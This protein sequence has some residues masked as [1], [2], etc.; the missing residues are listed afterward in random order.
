MKN[1]RSTCKNIVY[2][3]ITFNW[4]P[5]TFF[6]FLFLFEKFAH[7]HANNVFWS[8]LL[9]FLSLHF[10]S[11]Y[12]PIISPSQLHVLFLNTLQW[13]LLSAPYI[14]MML[15][16]YTRCSLHI[17][18]APACTRCFLHALGA[19]CMHMVLL[20]VHSAPCMHTV[21]P[22][23]TRCS[24][25]AH[26]SPGIYMGIGPSAGAWVA[27]QGQ[28]PWGKSHSPPTASTN[29]LGEAVHYPLPDP[30]SDFKCLDHMQVLFISTSCYKKS[31]ALVC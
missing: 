14:Y 22:T 25:H 4:V 2:L 11:L 18:G 26:G 6:R 16:T 29:C 10:P 19:P 31:R 21:L 17:F 8:N 13:S 27:S 7:V 24:P 30:C 15:L 20:H 12:L 5:C 1:L 9:S 28:D 3:L 23:R